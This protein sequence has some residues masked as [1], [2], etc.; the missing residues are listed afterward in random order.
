VYLAE[1]S[2]NRIVEFNGVTGANMGTFRSTGLNAP[3]ALTFDSTGNLFVTNFSGN[4]VRKY[5]VGDLTGT[6]CYTNAQG[7]LN[8]T[9][10]AISST[11]TL[12]INSFGNARVYEGS[13]LCSPAPLNIF[14]TASV[15]NPAGIAV[16]PGAAVGGQV[17]EPGA[18]AL[19][20]GTAT[21]GSLFALRGR[22]KR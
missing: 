2:A 5:G 11:G 3:F 19:L 14:T 9:G 10:I 13:T 8:P 7:L 15:A 1:R 6:T 16:K 22:R 17:P 21:V 20:M 12:L 4:S 18:I